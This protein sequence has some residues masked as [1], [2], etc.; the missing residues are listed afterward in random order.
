MTQIDILP[1]QTLSVKWTGRKGG[2]SLL[3]IAAE[4]NAKNL[5][6][7]NLNQCLAVLLAV[8]SVPF[9]M[10]D[11][12]ADNVMRKA[13]EYVETPAYAAVRA[14]AEE[15]GL[16]EVRKSIVVSAGSGMNAPHDMYIDSAIRVLFPKTPA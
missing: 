16:G 12:N 7:L 10:G 8:R 5:N 1:D 2:G 9:P 3:Q 15:I 4:G 11:H 13:L 6:R 14:K